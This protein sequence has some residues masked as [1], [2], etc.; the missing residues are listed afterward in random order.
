MHENN[1]SSAESWK[2]WSVL[3]GQCYEEM[4]QVRTN[5]QV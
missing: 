4:A 1:V 5:E 3:E 2:T